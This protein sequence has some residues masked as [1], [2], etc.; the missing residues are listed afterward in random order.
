MGTPGGFEWDADKNRQN[1]EKHGIDF[2]EAIEVFYGWYVVRPSDRSG[3]KRW[4]AI[5]ETETR[6]IVV[7][8]TWRG[9]QIRIISA[10]RARRN[11]KRAYRKE[12]MG[13]SPQGQ[14]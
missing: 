5:G 3:E 11:E 9:G 6:T 1:I 14:N 13:R 8:F 4:I 10:R 2:E 7:V 12:T